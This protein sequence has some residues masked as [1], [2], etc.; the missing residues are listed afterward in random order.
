MDFSNPETSL[1]RRAQKMGERLRVG[2]SRKGEARE[3][4]PIPFGR[5]FGK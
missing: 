4:R 2:S 5:I 3:R 1:R